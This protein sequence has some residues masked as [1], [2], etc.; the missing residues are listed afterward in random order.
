[1]RKVFAFLL[2][3]ACNLTG[4]PFVRDTVRKINSDS[5]SPFGDK[6]TVRKYVVRVWRVVT[7]NATADCCVIEAVHWDCDLSPL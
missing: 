4:T 6:Y 7:I 5:E 1:M 2:I 3:P